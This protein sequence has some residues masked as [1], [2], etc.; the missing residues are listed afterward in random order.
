[1]SARLMCIMRAKDE[2]HKIIRCLDSMPF[3]DGLVIADNGSSDDLAAAVEPYSATIIRTEG[4]DA[5]RD[6]A[7]VYAEAQAQGADWCLWMDADEEFEA[8]AA[9]SFRDLVVPGPINGW[10]FRVYPF[11]LSTEFWRMDRD[12]A[13]FTLR[14]Q[15]RLFRV[16]EGIHW[17]DPRPSAPGLPQGVTGA[18]G[19]SSLRIK[20]WTIEG[21]EDLERKLRFYSGLYPGRDYGHLRDGPDAVYKRW[22]E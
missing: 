16:Q 2:A 4:L 12:W 6:M 22:I 1:M 14:G 20:H 21:E 8:K 11:V 17:N 5:N 15:L 18:L 10:I 13:Q 9:E 19:R 3:L 7:L